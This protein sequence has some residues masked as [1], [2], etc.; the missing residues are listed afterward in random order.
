MTM[1]IIIHAKISHLLRQKSI[2]ERKEKK[3]ANVNLLDCLNASEYSV[4][5]VYP[6]HTIQM[7]DF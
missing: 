5:F 4:D 7:T 2:C 3:D 6:L 1:I